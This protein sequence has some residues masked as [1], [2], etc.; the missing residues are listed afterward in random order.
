MYTPKV[1]ECGK[2]LLEDEEERSAGRGRRES[3]DDREESVGEAL[4]AR[5]RRESE[6]RGRD[7]VTSG[8][9][10]RQLEDRERGEK[11]G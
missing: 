8:E 10:S 11:P 5:A 1:E 3:L 2:Q 6:V 4:K 9:G 7:T